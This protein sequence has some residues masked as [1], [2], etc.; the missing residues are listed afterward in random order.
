LPATS[1]LLDFF[2]FTQTPQSPMILAIPPG[3]ALLRIPANLARAGG[4]GPVGSLDPT[5]G[6]PS[7]VFGYAMFYQGAM[8]PIVHNV[9]ID[10]VSY[11][12]TDSGPQNG[13]EL[14]TYTTGLPLGNH[15]Y[16][17]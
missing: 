1:N 5:I 17:F 3:G 14:Y 4:Q 15:S 7:T 13:A 9:N 2:D 8:P 10:G 11:P 6:T 12:M 16:S